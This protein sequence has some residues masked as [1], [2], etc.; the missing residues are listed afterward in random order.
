VRLDEIVLRTLEREPEKGYQ[1]M[2]EVG[3]D[4]T[5]VTKPASKRAEPEA[6][7]PSESRK[8]GAIE[9]IALVVAPV[10]M[11]AVI[12]K[13]WPWQPSEEKPAPAEPAKT[14]QDPSAAAIAKAENL[15]KQDQPTLALES[16]EK[17]IKEDPENARLREL[18]VAAAGRHVDHLAAEHGGAVARDWLAA[19]IREKSYLRPLAARHAQLDTTVT[20][21]GLFDK[22]GSTSMKVRDTASDL[23]RQH[24]KFPEVPY[25][26]AAVVEKYWVPEAVLWLYREYFARGGSRDD[27]HPFE[28]CA[29]IFNA[30]EPESEDG[31]YGHAFAREFYP[32]RRVAWAEGT[33]SDGHGLALVNALAILDEARHPA[34]KDPVLRALVQALTGVETAAA[35]KTLLAAPPAQRRRAAEVLERTIKDGNL[36]EDD[37]A[38]LKT[39]LQSLAP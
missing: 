36:P 25:A 29:K 15:L 28:I 8:W 9:T 20:L 7:E 18:A 39:L 33:A 27:P 4:V 23:L 10:L 6:V 22:G 2:G 32:Q 19:R 12:A 24:A 21:Q 35:Q 1:S 30:N 3:R 38:Y 37:L 14:A 11:I 5:R 31:Q 16:A 17:Q 13:G 26:A 34:A